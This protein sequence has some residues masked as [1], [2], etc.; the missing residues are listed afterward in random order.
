MSS[1]GSRRRP[2]ARSR[3]KRQNA[4]RLAMS[5]A[6]RSFGT[7]PKAA[8]IDSIVSS[9]QLVTC[10]MSSSRMPISSTNTS[11]VSGVENWLASSTSPLSM[12]RSMSPSMTL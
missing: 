5:S 3:R 4:S 6:S 10:G 2:S 12:K 8:P 11:T 1:R 7:S 9:T